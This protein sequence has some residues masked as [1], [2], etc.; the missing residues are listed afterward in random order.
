MP[1]TSLTP[2]Q[3][4]ESKIK[5]RIRESIGDLLPDEVLAEMMKKAMQE[6]FFTRKEDQPDR[7][8]PKVI[9]PSWFEDAVHSSLKSHV[10]DHLKRWLAENGAE[11]TK[12]IQEYLV[13]NSPQIIA[14]FFVGVL[15]NQTWSV[16]SNV[17]SG[18][19]ESLRQ[20][21]NSPLYFPPSI[22]R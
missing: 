3:L 13:Q 19:M 1:E 18:M 14:A 8:S 21:P 9:K 5:D 4:F 11:L 22:P 16:S 7:Y 12:V 17:L 15:Q 20:N 6:M 10:E 2:Q